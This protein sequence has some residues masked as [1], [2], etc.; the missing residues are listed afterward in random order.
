MKMRGAA[1]RINTKWE[2]KTLF[3][4]YCGRYHHH[5]CPVWSEARARYR[6]GSTVRAGSFIF[7]SPLL[8]LYLSLLLSVTITA[9]L[10][11]K[12]SSSLS[13]NLENAPPWYSY[14]FVLRPGLLE[15]ARGRRFSPVLL[16]RLLGPTHRY[17]RYVTDSCTAYCSIN[18]PSE[19]PDIYLG[20][21]IEFSPWAEVSTS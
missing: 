7:N 8:V 13:Y 10:S 17:L 4:Q 16:A 15:L 6:C 21:D 9:I 5:L 2:A 1:L 12:S 14:C 11:Q 19:Y 3:L 18:S 20:L